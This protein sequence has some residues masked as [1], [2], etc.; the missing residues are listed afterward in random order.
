MSLNESAM[1]LADVLADHAGPWRS[2]VSTVGGAR[3]IDCGGAVVG[4][5]RAGLQMARVCTRRARRSCAPARAAIGP[6]VQV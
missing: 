5:L 4:G 6:E 3:V 2:A 1:A